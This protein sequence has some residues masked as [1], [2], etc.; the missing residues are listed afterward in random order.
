MLL[1]PDM[2]T[3]NKVERVANIVGTKRIQTV[4]ERRRTKHSELQELQALN[5]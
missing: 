2:P 3:Y 5:H 4:E 1:I